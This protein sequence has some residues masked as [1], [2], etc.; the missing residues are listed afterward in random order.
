[1]MK[2]TALGGMTTFALGRVVVMKNLAMGGGGGA[3]GMLMSPTL[4]CLVQIIVHGSTTIIV[5]G[6]Q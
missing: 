5:A 2:S 3:V 6:R 1:M 4:L